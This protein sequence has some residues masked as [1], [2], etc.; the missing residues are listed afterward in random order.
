MLREVRAVTRNRDEA[1]AGHVLCHLVVLFEAEHRLWAQ[2]VPPVE[3]LAEAEEHERAALILE[4][5]A[6]RDVADLLAQRCDGLPPALTWPVLQQ[7]HHFGGV[8]LHFLGVVDDRHH[9]QVD[10][11]TPGEGQA[12]FVQLAKRVSENFLN[13]CDIHRGYFLSVG[14]VTLY[15]I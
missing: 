8:L 15:H 13:S 12:V 3:Y 9:E 7:L 5:T 11:L 4:G 2:N 10:H 1:E 6:C 14:I